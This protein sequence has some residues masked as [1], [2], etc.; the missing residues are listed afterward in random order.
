MTKDL[1]SH[2]QLPSNQEEF[3]YLYRNYT[4]GGVPG[5]GALPC[6]RICLPCPL[7]RPCRLVYLLF[8][9]FLRKRPRSLP[10]HFLLAL[11]WTPDLVSS[12]GSER[13]PQIFLT[14]PFLHHLL[15]LF[16]LL[17]PDPLTHQPHLIRAWSP[18]V[19]SNLQ[20][21]RPSHP[22]SKPHY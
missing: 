20:Q 15:T 6:P 8:F 14:P 11:L 13:A 4:P 7:K 5:S 19:S 1:Y 18:A 22:S 21:S 10:A 3:R 16:V 17:Y 2:L 9:G 12:Q